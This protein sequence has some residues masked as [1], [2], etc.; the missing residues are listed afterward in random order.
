MDFEWIFLA[1][2]LKH[3]WLPSQMRQL[4]IKIS[5]KKSFFFSKNAETSVAAEPNESRKIAK[6]LKKTIKKM[7]L[8]RGPQGPF[9]NQIY[10]KR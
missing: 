9:S 4:I 2:T 5:S 8:Q 6:F 7:T 1:K 3:R 10:P